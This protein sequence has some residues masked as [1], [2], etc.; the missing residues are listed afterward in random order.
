M[1]RARQVFFEALFRRCSCRTSTSFLARRSASWYGIRATSRGFRGSRQFQVDLC[2]R[3]SRSKPRRRTHHSRSGSILLPFL[4]RLRRFGG[5]FGRHE[6][7]Q[8]LFGSISFWVPVPRRGMGLPPG[9]VGHVPPSFHPLLQPRHLHRTEPRDKCVCSEANEEGR[10]V[11]RL[12]VVVTG[13]ASWILRRWI[14]PLWLGGGSTSPD[15]G[16]RPGPEEG[17]RWGG[18]QD[19]RPM[20]LPVD[21]NPGRDGVLGRE[22]Q[23]ID[24]TLPAWGDTRECLEPTI[25]TRV[26]TRHIRDE[27]RNT[28]D[29]RSTRE[30]RTVQGEQSYNKTYQQVRKRLLIDPTRVPARETSVVESARHEE[31]DRHVTG[32]GRC[33]ATQINGHRSNQGRRQDCL[34]ASNRKGCP[35][36]SRPGRFHAVRGSP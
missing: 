24:R 21:P 29:G 8:L 20:D 22:P 17:D 14:P 32:A 12:G 28:R 13:R 31:W 34:P 10:G 6:W 2:F 36:R 4:L 11:V 23:G 5:T 26:E 15:V 1:P 16:D 9:H 30:G 35:P 3:T 27:R 19:P 18:T 25:P 33:E 7:L